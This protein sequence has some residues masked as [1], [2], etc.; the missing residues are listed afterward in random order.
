MK[1]NV[2]VSGLLERVCCCAVRVGTT[3]GRGQNRIVHLTTIRV[4]FARTDDG[5]TYKEPDLFGRA[6]DTYE[7]KISLGENILFTGGTSENADYRDELRNKWF[8]DIGGKVP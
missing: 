2:M 8:D 1:L 7:I 4:D 6:N 5:G 3:I